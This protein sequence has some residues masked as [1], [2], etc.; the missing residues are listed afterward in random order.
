MGSVGMR[1]LLAVVTLAVGGATSVFAQ[2]PEATTREAAI[3]Q[4]QAQK[5]AVLHPYVPGKVEGLMNRAEAILV[6]G[7]PAWHPSFESAYYGGGFT[8]GAGYARHVSP[9]NQLDVRG[10]YTILGYKRIEAE[11]TAPRLF[12]RRGS[13]SVLG[14]WRQAT[15][16]A[17]YG[18]GMGTSKDDRTDFD[19]RQPYGSAMLTVFADAAR[20]RCCAEASSC[21]GGRSA[22]P[23]GTSHRSTPS[24]R[25]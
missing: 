3:A 10:S 15:Q 1:R 20:F 24:T 18:T 19:F 8:L 14:G 21:P 4:L 9:Y 23:R 22:L 2:E 12:H 5:V 11:F 7:V 6:S 13:L 25:L 17:F 16:A